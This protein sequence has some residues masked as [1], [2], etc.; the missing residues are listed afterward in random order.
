MNRVVLY[1]ESVDQELVKKIGGIISFCEHQEKAA[2]ARNEC[3]EICR[4]RLLNQKK[5]P[6]I[7]AAV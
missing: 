2:D 3:V 5:A 6:I 4:K 7:M 1:Q